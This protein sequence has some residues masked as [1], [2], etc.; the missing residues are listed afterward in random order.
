ML[1]KVTVAICCVEDE[2]NQLSTVSLR[3]ITYKSMLSIDI[4]IIVNSSG[5]QRLER[6]WPLN[7]LD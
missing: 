5:T 1:N 7:T 3:H 2:S 4:Q 6:T